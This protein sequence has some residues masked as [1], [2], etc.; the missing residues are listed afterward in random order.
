MLNV[1]E[2]LICARHWAEC[3]KPW[4]HWILTKILRGKGYDLVFPLY[5]EVK[6]SVEGYISC[7]RSYK[8]QA[9][10]QVLLGAPREREAA[11][12]LVTVLVCSST[13]PFYRG[14]HWF[15]ICERTHR[16]SWLFRIRHRKKTWSLSSLPSI[17]H[18]FSAVNHIKIGLQHEA[19]I[20]GFTLRIPAIRW[21]VQVSRIQCLFWIHLML[22]LETEDLSWVQHITF[23]CLAI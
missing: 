21:P 12:V 14:R 2:C 6:G 5:R 9:Q 7:P 8:Q 3:F 23:H 1:F 20:L 15:Q 10:S 19:C 11:R 16:K 13:A 4:S 17:P 18:S 22:R